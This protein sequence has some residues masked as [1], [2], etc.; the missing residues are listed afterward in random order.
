MPNCEDV[1]AAKELMSKMSNYFA[2]KDSMLE[3][4][5]SWFSQ[6]TK[7][8]IKR[9]RVGAGTS[10]GTLRVLV[11]MEETKAQLMVLN[12]EGK[13]GK[14]SGGGD[15]YL[16]NLCYYATECGSLPGT[17]T[18]LCRV[19]VI[20]IEVTG[21]ELAISGAVLTSTVNINPFFCISL[22]YN[23]LDSYHL[24]EVAQCIRALKDSL[25]E[26]KEYYNYHNRHPLKEDPVFPY[27]TC[28]SFNGEMVEFKF[29][30]LVNLRIFEAELVVV[31]KMDKEK[32]AARLPSKLIVKFTTAYCKAAHESMASV[33]CAPELFGMEEL[34]GGWKMVVMAKLPK[35][36]KPADELPKAGSH[37]Q[38][39]GAVLKRLH[40]FGFVH[41]DFRPNNVFVFLNSSQSQRSTS[42]SSVENSSGSVTNN[43]IQVIDFDWSGPE[44]IACYPF[45]MN[46][47][48][49]CW[50]EGA[51]DGQLLLKEH[52]EYFLDHLF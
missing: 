48:D 50:P 24:K 35:E 28:F 3:E 7:W 21:P 34:A 10:D 47:T 18:K 40:S 45:G 2:S 38:E 36:M 52:D 31:G 30:Q 17:V 46:H 16:Q 8:E 4:F 33:C 22:L 32:A 39:I 14:G 13:V 20:L 15:S 19:P 29:T 26:L 23:P 6:Y 37:K 5:W 51:S 43:N 12:M 49:I 11:E 27:K 44:G 41:G 25:H 42:S 9:E 1:E